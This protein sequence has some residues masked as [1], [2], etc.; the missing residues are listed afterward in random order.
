M[1]ASAASPSPLP[2][3]TCTTYALPARLRPTPPRRTPHT[4]NTPA[5]RRGDPS[6]D[7]A[8]LG[9]TYDCFGSGLLPIYC[10]EF[11]MAWAPGV[12]EQW[13]PPAAALPF[14]AGDRQFMRLEVGGWV[15]RCA[16][17]GGRVRCIKEN[18]KGGSRQFQKGA[19]SP[20]P[21]QTRRP[22]RGLPYHVRAPHAI[23]RGWRRR[24][25]GSLARSQMGGCKCKE[26]RLNC[27][28]RRPSRCASDA[29]APNLPR[30]SSCSA[31]SVRAF[32]TA[33]LAFWGSVESADPTYITHFSSSIMEGAMIAPGPPPSGAHR[34]P[35]GLQGVGVLVGGA[36]QHLHE[37]G[38]RPSLH[39]WA[40]PQPPH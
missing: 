12:G 26:R 27:R 6:A 34:K 10:R 24:R 17:S 13:A 32:I 19:A 8:P 31:F 1:V 14:G 39:P 22:A 36:G 29:Q 4:H 20:P 3:P 28:Q 5:H 38:A 2:P 7:S 11:Y 23:G 35:G 40:R 16:S 25:H 15:G 9:E 30:K 21:L 18:R 33:Q 37:D